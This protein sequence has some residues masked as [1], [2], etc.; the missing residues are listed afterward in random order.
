MFIFKNEFTHIIALIYVDD[1]L[2]MGN[3][4]DKLEEVKAYL[5]TQFNIKDLGPL[6]YFLGI[7]VARSPD[8]IVISQCKYTLD[9]LED[10]G[11]QGS[12]PCSFPMEQNLC[13]KKDDNSPEVDT[14]K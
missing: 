3:N 8:D 6:K 4:N 11:I 2:L 10:C 14:P 12:C 7:K 1:I 9:I 5:Q 13:L